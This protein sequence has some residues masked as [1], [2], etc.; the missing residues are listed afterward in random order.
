MA[1]DFRDF[2]VV[3]TKGQLRREKAEAQGMQ[4]AL[5]MM[6]NPSTTPQAPALSGVGDGSA[7]VM[8]SF[9]FLFE[10]IKSS[11][12]VV[13]SVKFI[14][15]IN[16]ERK[17]MRKWR[18]THVWT[19]FGSDLLFWQKNLVVGEKLKLV[20]KFLPKRLIDCARNCKYN[21]MVGVNTVLLDGVFLQLLT[22]IVTCEVNC[23]WYILAGRRARFALQH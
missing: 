10:V 5:A 8:V 23:L 1:D 9:A 15:K 22:D 7:D 6:A 4:R 20:K 18:L 14:S 12:K 11:E 21:V 17:S 16:C 2:G 3:K 13:R 19:V